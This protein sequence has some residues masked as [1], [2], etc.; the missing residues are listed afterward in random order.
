MVSQVQQKTT[1]E[2]EIEK[3]IIHKSRRKYMGCA[4]GSHRQTGERG[5]SKVRARPGVCALIK[6]CGWSALSFPRLRPNWPIQTKE[7][8]GFGKLHGVMKSI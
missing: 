7:S 1:K 6:V 5:Q 8:G 4:D 3:R 2:I